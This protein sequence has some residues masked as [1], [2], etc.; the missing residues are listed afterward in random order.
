[1]NLWDIWGFY[2][3]YIS[4]FQIHVKGR[5][6]QLIYLYVDIKIWLND[7]IE[8]SGDQVVN[9]AWDIRTQVL[10]SIRQD[11]RKGAEIDTDKYSL[12]YT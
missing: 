1:M 3:I 5:P 8:L 6:E 4:L 10:Q 11:N 7:V 9:L 12:I 2:A